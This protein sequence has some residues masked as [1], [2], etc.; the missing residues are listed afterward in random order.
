[1]DW[2]TMTTGAAS[3]RSCRAAIVLRV[4]KLYVEWFVEAGWKVF[5]WRIVTADVRV[6]DSAHRY[7][8]RCELAA[9]TISAGFMTRKSRRCRVVSAF[10]TRVA[11]EGT[12]PLARVKEFGVVAV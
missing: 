7:L 8:R 10:V 11:A 9:M 12:V 1:M 5:Q 6:A 2:R 3:L 4:V